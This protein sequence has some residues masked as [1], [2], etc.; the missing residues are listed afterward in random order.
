MIFDLRNWLFLHYFNTPSWLGRLVPKLLASS[1]CPNYLENYSILIYFCIRTTTIEQQRCKVCQGKTPKPAHVQSSQRYPPL[2]SESV[3][4][5]LITRIQD[6]QATFHSRLGPFN[7]NAR[8]VRQIEANIKPLRF[9]YLRALE[10]KSDTSFVRHS[11]SAFAGIGHLSVF[12]LETVH[13]YSNRQFDP[14]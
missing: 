12:V 14:A 7:F 10:L 13:Y 5:Y 4:G 11:F 2:L 6:K 8:G 1:Y 9:C 3:L